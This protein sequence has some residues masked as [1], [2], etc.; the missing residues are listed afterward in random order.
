M[1]QP[2][3]LPLLVA[4]FLLTLPSSVSSRSFLREAEA[5]EV[6]ADPVGAEVDSVSAADECQGGCFRSGGCPRCAYSIIFE[7][8]MASSPERCGKGGY[9]GGELGV[10]NNVESYLGLGV[11]GFLGGDDCGARYGVRGRLR[12]WPD[13]RIG[14]DVSP[15]LALDGDVTMNYPAFSGVIAVSFFGLIGPFVQV[16]QVRYRHRETWDTFFGVRLESYAVFAGIGLILAAV[17]TAW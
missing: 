3:G 4:L 9:F 1:K 15:G 14:I 2:Y 13:R 7:L 17:A 10:L 6:E 8:S 16:D 11:S 5:G 12:F